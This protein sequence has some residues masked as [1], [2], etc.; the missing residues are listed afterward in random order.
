M[1]VRVLVFGLSFFGLAVALAVQPYLA[2]G[3][4]PD[5]SRPCTVTGTAGPDLLQGTAGNDVICGLGGNDTM[6]GNSGNDIL[7][8]GPGN[9]RMQGDSGADVLQGGPGDDWLWGR[10]G[11]HGRGYDRYRYDQ[12]IDRL[13][14]VEAKM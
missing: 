4:T 1:R 2:S 9:D 8:G 6:G 11:R 3:H 7:R 14:A 5:L 10:D 13:V 12:S